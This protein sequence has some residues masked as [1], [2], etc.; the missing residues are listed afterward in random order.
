[1]EQKET[2]K[3][4]QRGDLVLH[5]EDPKTHGMLMEVV[6]VKG[7]KARTVYL[8]AKTPP[9]TA[10]NGSWHAFADLLNPALFLRTDEFVQ[11]LREQS[12]W[13]ARQQNAGT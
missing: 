13:K 6:K 11:T 3:K 2:Q 1:M 7:N 8:D 12:R 4:W 5:K 10:R 9:R